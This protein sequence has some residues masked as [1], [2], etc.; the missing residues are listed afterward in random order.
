M[1]DLSASQAS[2]SF[3]PHEA[4]SEA[5]W[6]RRLARGL[7]RDPATA[8]DVEQETWLAILKQPGR[9]LGQMRA[10]TTAVARARAVDERRSR[11]R[12][13]AR[14]RYAARD[15]LQ[16]SVAELSARAEQQKKLVELV[17]E[18]DE[19]YREVVL[20]HYFQ[21]QRLDEIAEAAGLPPTTVRTRLARA[22][23]MLRDKLDRSSRGDRSQWMGALAPIAAMQGPTLP[24]ASAFV[25]V[26]VG[27]LLVLCASFLT[28]WALGASRSP[29]PD[30]PEVSRVQRERDDEQRDAPPPPD[31][32]LGSVAIAAPLER[33][34]AIVEPGLVFGTLEDDRGTPLGEAK[35]ELVR[36]GETFTGSV[37]AVGTWA[38]LGIAAGAWKLKAD[39]DGCVPMEREIEITEDPGSRRVDLAF[40]R[41]GLE[42]LRPPSRWDEALFVR[43]M[44]LSSHD[45]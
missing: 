37:G 18:L 11:E 1:S 2:A 20:R 17:M 16:P 41:E 4:L 36:D 35:I 5:A 10:W 7:V 6:V 8:D 25:Q 27:S 30:A 15:E 23:E 43:W 22:L 32:G 28:W 13:E 9:R 19:K 21:D 12:R 42:T 44:T 40:V 45:R 3:D 24:S 39:A 34:A 26:V 33:S 29:A 31:T 14:E 38:V